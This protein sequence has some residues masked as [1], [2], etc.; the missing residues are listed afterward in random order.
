MSPSL[1]QSQLQ[2]LQALTN[3]GALL[4]QADELLKC[5]AL[6]HEHG[7]PQRQ[8]LLDDHVTEAPAASHSLRQDGHLASVIPKG[9]AHGRDKQQFK[10][11]EEAL[12]MRVRQC[13]AAS[14]ESATKVLRLFAVRCMPM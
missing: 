12:L 8:A 10:D 2:G 7:L 5:S 4:H 11:Q 9:A 13:F 3:L 14:H 6:G 1:L